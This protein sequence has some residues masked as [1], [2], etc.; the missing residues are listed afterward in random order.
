MSQ[1]KGFPIPLSVVA[2]DFV[3]AA[4]FAWGFYLYISEKRGIGFII[5]GVLLMTPLVFHL[6]QLMPGRNQ[7]SRSN[8]NGSD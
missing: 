3:G 6:V 4:L 7:S 5:A 1:K 8:T 2:L